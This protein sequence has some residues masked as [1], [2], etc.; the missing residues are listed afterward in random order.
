MATKVALEQFCTTHEVPPEA[1]IDRALRDFLGRYNPSQGGANAK[2]KISQDLSETMQ[3]I[4]GYLQ[5][6]K[7][8]PNDSR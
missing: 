1:V 5:R 8:R 3:R 2:S 7:Q 4:T 6:S